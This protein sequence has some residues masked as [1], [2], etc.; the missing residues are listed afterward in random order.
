MLPQPVALITGASRGLGRAMAEAFALKNYAVA[1]NTRTHLE[2]ARATEKILK[3]C[4]A[5]TLVCKADVS[6]SADVNAMIKVVSEAWGRIDVLVNN[7]GITK[8]QLIAKMTD[9]EWRSV[10]A[11]NLDGPFYCTRAVLPLMRDQKN[12]SIVNVGS[13]LALREARG[14]AN[15]SASKAA[16]L[17]LTRSTAV[18][19]GGFNIRANAVLPGFHVT[20]M[21]QDVWKKFESNIRSQHLLDELPKRDGFADFVVSIAELKT[22]TGQVFSFESRLV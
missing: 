4:G 8:N 9:E 6:S 3:K 22:V 5:P 18:E 7:A 20:D 15:Y 14:A 12:G 21:N 2:D 1:I 16:V 17:S 11:T 13:Y 10:M 19:E